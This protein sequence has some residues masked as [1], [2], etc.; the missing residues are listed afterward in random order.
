MIGFPKTKRA[1]AR[2]LLDTYHSM[3]CVACGKTGCDPAHILS[4][5]AGGD[6]VEWNLMPLC[7][8]HHAIQHAQG[9][10]FMADH[11]PP[12]RIDLT[13]KGWDFEESGKL[14]R[15]C[16]HHVRAGEVCPRCGW[17]A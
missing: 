16:E 3:R 9:W 14:F 12:L 5:G 13:N 1:I 11:F 10:L 17:R 2:D 4:R 15:Y 8:A 6:D 7:R